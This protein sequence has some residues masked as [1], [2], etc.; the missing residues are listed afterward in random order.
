MRSICDP[1]K[2]RQETT[3]QDYL[4]LIGEERAA[5]SEGEVGQTIDLIF[6]GGLFI[7]GIYELEIHQNLLGLPGASAVFKR[8][9]AS[10]ALEGQTTF[11]PGVQQKYVSRFCACCAP[12]PRPQPCCTL[13]VYGTFTFP[14]DI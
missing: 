9:F 8:P 6:S 14:F 5:Q 4:E 11:N 1:G 2:A 3:E 10:Y 7:N 13:R 12:L